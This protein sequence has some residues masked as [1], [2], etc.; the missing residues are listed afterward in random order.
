MFRIG[1][2]RW[3]QMART[4]SGAVA[5]AQLGEEREFGRRELHEDTYSPYNGAVEERSA[6]DDD[7]DDNE[8]YAR[9]TKEE[10]ITNAI[11]V[12]LHDIRPVKLLKKEEEQTLAASIERG[13]AARARLETDL[14]AE[15]LPRA[16][17]EVAEG[18]VART[19]LTEANLRLVVNEA[20]KFLNRG[21]SLSD[22]I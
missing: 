19:K 20:K 11:G 13:E 16:R 10:E 1:P 17:I 14:S 15:E 21:L 12:Y 5:E 9:S 2:E 8:T 22:L 6:P 3:K 4:R 18:D 7:D